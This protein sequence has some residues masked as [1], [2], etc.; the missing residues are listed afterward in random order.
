MGTRKPEAIAYAVFGEDNDGYMYLD[1]PE[2]ARCPGCGR[3]ADPEFVNPRFTLGKGCDLDWSTTYDGCR[4][5]SARVRAECLA[6][7][8]G[9]MRFLGLPAAPSFF[10]LLVDR[11]VEF[12][13]ERRRTRFTDLCDVCGRYRSVTGA[14]PVFLN[15]APAPWAPGFYRTDVEFGTG[16]E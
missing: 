2:V 1:A 3:V 4:I 5:V 8:Y 6:A 16:D 12:D 7:A 11:V 15:R 9:G 14:T 10:R 13:A